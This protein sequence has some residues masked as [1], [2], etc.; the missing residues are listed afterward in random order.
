MVFASLSDFLVFRFQ[1]TRGQWQKV[2]YISAGL[3]V[4]GWI[5]FLLLGSGKQ[6][7]WNTP[8]EDLLVPVDIPR[9]PRIP[10]MAEVL[11]IKN[12]ETDKELLCDS[13]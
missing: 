6:Q 1:P 11:S 12:Q 10:V 13:S 9:E 5:T 3:Y 8:F 4:V 7:S 2:F